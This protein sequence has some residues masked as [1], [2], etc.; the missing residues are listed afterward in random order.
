MGPKLKRKIIHRGV[1][2]PFG[3][4]KERAGSSPRFFEKFTSRLKING[5]GWFSTSFVE[6]ET[7]PFNQSIFTFARTVQRRHYFY[8]FFLVRYPSS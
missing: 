7:S 6:Q 8:P 4:E 2:I 3:V 1:R 5:K